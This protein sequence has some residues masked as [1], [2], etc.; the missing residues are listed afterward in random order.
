[1]EKLVMFYYQSVYNL[2][3]WCLRQYQYNYKHQ[4]LFKIIDV[5]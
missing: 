2:Y 1:M 3:Q 5:N 4:L